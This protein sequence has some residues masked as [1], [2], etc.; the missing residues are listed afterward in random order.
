MML[1]L[2]ALLVAPLPTDSF[3][4]LPAPDTI[5]VV[6]VERALG[7][8]RSVRSFGPESLSL[9]QL[10]QLLWAAQGNSAKPGGRTAP[11]AGATYPLEVFV[12]SGRV[13]GL[14]SGLY[15]YDGN[16]HTL[17]RLGTK[18]LR[19]E[20]GSA[21]Y[22]Q[23]WVVDAAA[24]VVLAADYSRT[25]SRYGERGRRYVHMEAGHVGQNVHLQCAALGLGTVMVG[26]F[27]D[28]E[29]K[30]LIGGRFDPLYLMPVGVPR[31]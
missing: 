17:R 8:R 10:G 4:R 16:S 30:R 26:A 1:W 28:R 15:R 14:G 29:A 9:S 24:V 27:D 25:T 19:R 3:V 5:G 20:L 31:R 13:R 22:G 21:A 7:S 23:K 11:S 18:D 6:S 2:C 12:A